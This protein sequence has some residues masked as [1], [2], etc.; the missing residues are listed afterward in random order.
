MLRG[1]KEINAAAGLGV[2]D[3]GP[4]E[5]EA[6]AASGRRA[7]IRALSAQPTGWK[8]HLSAAILSV[9]SSLSLSRTVSD[10]KS[11]V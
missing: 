2:G 11:V 5:S 6:A 3:V 9:C 7:L 10:R 1:V 4:E 8:V